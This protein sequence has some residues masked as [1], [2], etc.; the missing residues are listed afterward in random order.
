[1]L[2]N[3]L[4]IFTHDYYSGLIFRMTHAFFYPIAVGSALTIVGKISPKETNK[5]VLGISVGSVLGLSITTYLGFN[6]GFQITMLWFILINILALISTI[7]FIPNFEGNNE[8]VMMQVIHAKSKLFLLSIGYVFFMIV[9]IS[10]TY[11]YIP[12]Y[13]NEVTKINGKMLFTVLFMMGLTSIFGTTLCGYLLEKSAKLTSLFYSI[14]FSVFM[15]ILGFFVEN[16]FIESFII[17]IFGILDG[18]GYTIS[19]YWVTSSIPQSP[20]FA[21]GLFLLLRNTC[22]FVGT[23]IGGFIIEDIHI[24][25]IFIGSAL[26]MILASPF[27]LIR[28]KI[29]PNLF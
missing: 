26:M 6:Y 3:I 5:V 17:L 13:L 7:L 14:C 19:Q 10:I 18:F 24:F 1:M 12:S 22:I 21:N 28:M 9:S 2:C 27:V 23:I 8:P 11:N 4:E 16:P 29:Y 25:Y 20:E 15:L